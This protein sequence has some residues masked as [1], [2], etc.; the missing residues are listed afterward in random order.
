[1][2]FSYWG[3][4]AVLYHPQSGNVHLLTYLN[5]R[6]LDLLSSNKEMD[7]IVELCLTDSMINTQIEDKDQLL[8]LISNLSTEFR[9]M[10]LLDN[11]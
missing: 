7:K 3:D 1:M 4:H 8:N 10:G 6:L 11:Y 9:K 5:A 2:I